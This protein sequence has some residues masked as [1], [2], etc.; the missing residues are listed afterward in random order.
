MNDFIEVLKT[1]HQ[2]A[3]KRMQAA[4]Q[5]LLVAQ[6][7]FQNTSQEF[8]SLNYVLAMEMQRTQQEAA[9]AKATQETPSIG[10][11]TQTLTEPT[12]SATPSPIANTPEITK[13]AMVR[14]V[15]R[16]SP[17]G[18]TPDEIWKQLKAQMGDHAYIYSVLK[19][20]KDRDEITKRRGKY[21]LKHQPQSD[22]VAAQNGIVN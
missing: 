16:H 9:T 8:N 2:D 5:K 20:L 6:A 17:N 18:I 15:L 4:Q 7:E 10:P 22:E 11:P 19:R 1:R 12:A 3:Q 13:T 21:Y 14:N